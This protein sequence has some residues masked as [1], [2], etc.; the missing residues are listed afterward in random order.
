[1]TRQRAFKRLI[2]E[3]MAHTG[4][5]YAAARRHFFPDDAADRPTSPTASG[6]PA[7]RCAVAS[8]PRPRPSRASSPTPA[9]PRRPTTDPS[10]RRWSS[11]SAAASGPGYILWEFK[12]GTTA[13]IVTLGFRIDWQYPERWTRAGREPARRATSRSSGPRARRRPRG[14]WTRPSRPGAP[15]RLGRPRWSSARGRCPTRGR[16]TGATRSCC[17][18]RADDDPDIV[19][20]DERGEAPMRVRVGRL[21]TARGRIGSYKHMQFTIDGRPRP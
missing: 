21:A 1:M 20:V 12:H 14:R 7:T 19:L 2:R 15:D 3:R 13:A 8:I 18:G 16:A 9:S 11:A 5:H 6:R 17:I 4:E 10:A